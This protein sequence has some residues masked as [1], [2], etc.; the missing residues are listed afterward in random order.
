MVYWKSPHSHGD[1]SA[2]LNIHSVLFDGVVGSFSVNDTVNAELPQDHFVQL[3]K[4]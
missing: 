3:F 2:F 1:A 4:A